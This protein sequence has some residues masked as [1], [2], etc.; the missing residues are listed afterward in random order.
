MLPSDFPSAPFRTP[1]DPAGDGAD[2]IVP[3]G[4][5]GRAGKLTPLLESIAGDKSAAV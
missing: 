2:L 3:I 4:R 5:H 1:D